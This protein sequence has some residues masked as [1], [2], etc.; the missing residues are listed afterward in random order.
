MNGRSADEMDINELD[1]KVECTYWSQQ[2]F[3][4][5]SV[6]LHLRGTA[7]ITFDEVFILE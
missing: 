3:A 7:L 1:M 4:F 5:F 6:G 2:K